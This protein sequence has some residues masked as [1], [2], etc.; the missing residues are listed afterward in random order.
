MG[1]DT[2]DQMS[3]HILLHNNKGIATLAVVGLMAWTLGEAWHSTTVPLFSKHLLRT[4]LVVNPVGWFE[5]EKPWRLAAPTRGK[6]NK[7]KGWYNL[8]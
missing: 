5:A 2:Q 7:Q 1:S 4:Y 6:C 3:K 8:V